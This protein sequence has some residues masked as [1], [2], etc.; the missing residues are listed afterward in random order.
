MG[1][2]IIVFEVEHRRKLFVD[3]Q[4]VDALEECRRE[5]AT[6]KLGI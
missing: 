6:R 5:K 3:V 2:I 4:D 1:S